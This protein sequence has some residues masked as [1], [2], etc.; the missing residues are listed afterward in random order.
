VILA[1]KYLKVWLKISKRFGHGSSLNLEGDKFLLCQSF[2]PTQRCN[3]HLKIK[4]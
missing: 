3:R 2:W 4:C 1:L